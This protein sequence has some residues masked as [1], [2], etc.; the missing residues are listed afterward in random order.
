MVITD[1]ETKQTFNI[2]TNGILGAFIGQELSSTNSD[3]SGLM[4]GAV[5]GREVIKLLAGCLNMVYHAT[6][7]SN[8]ANTAISMAR[9]IAEQAHKTGSF[10]KGYSNDER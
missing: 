6:G 5:N 4:L 3:T 10:T 7:N 9:K 2:E 8:E 1:N